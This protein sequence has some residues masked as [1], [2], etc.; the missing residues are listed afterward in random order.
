MLN[1]YKK[2]TYVY[3][4]VQKLV[5]LHLRLI[6]NMHFIKVKNNDRT[7]LQSM[8]YFNKCSDLKSTP[9]FKLTVKFANY[10]K[11]TQCSLDSAGVPAPR[12]E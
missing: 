1:I 8:F 4:N 5:N 10:F 9:R 2:I 12:G 6:F 11:W 3:K 7:E